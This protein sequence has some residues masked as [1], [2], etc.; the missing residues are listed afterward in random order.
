VTS[1]FLLHFRPNCHQNN[2]KLANLIHK[3]TV[4]ACSRG[5]ESW[6]KIGLGCAQAHFSLIKK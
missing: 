2:N 4:V 5:G 1:E 6:V 3:K